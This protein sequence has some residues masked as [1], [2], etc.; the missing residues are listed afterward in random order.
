MQLN[1]D[2]LTH[3][4]TNKNAYHLLWPWSL[5]LH[6]HQK[7]VNNVLIPTVL[8]KEGKDAAEMIWHWV[9]ETC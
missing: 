8:G 4:K 3:T 2:L 6:S 5:I 9:K 1:I 7:T